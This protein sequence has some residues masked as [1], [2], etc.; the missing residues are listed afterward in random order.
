MHIRTALSTLPIPLRGKE[1]DALLDLQP[2]IERVYTAG[3]HDDI[4]YNQPLVDP[5]LPAEDKAWMDQLLR[6][7]G[8]RS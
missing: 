6:A 7:A 2:L 4:D 1:P 3:G 8:R 5:P